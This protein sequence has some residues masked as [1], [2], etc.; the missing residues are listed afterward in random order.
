MQIPFIR[1]LLRPFPSMVRR[2]HIQPS[3]HRAIDKEFIQKRLPELQGS[4]RVIEAV[5]LRERPLDEAFNPNLDTF[6]IPLGRPLNPIGMARLQAYLAKKTDRYF[7]E[8]R[9]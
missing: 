7:I 6:H 2:F 9:F 5:I 8:I 3:I 1:A 4:G